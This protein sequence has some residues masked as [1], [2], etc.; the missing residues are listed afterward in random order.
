MRERALADPSDG[1]SDGRR[2]LAA[3]LARPSAS[4]R[5]LAGSGTLTTEKLS[6]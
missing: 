3:R 2:R 4:S 6:K 1:R 5:E